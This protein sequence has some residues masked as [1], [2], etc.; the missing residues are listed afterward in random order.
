MTTQVYIIGA[1]RTAIG[2]FQGQ[3]AHTSSPQLGAAA[4]KAAV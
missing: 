4:I 3:F 1:K 2:S